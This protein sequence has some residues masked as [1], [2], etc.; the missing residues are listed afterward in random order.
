LEIVD[1]KIVEY[2]ESHKDEIE[3]EIEDNLAQ[4]EEILSTIDNPIDIS[5][6]LESSIYKM[7][8]SMIQKLDANLQTRY[9]KRLSDLR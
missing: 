2:Q 8:K 5:S 1:Q 9:N 7:T 6:V 4:I 3:Q